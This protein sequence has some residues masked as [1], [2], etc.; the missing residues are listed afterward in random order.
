M[1]GSVTD[2][3]DIALGMNLKASGDK[4]IFLLGTLLGMT[5]IALT[6]GLG[7]NIDFSGLGDLIDLPM[8]THSTGMQVR[9]SF[10]IATVYVPDLLV[11]DEW[12]AVGDE[13]FRS[14]AEERLSALV[15][16]TKILVLASHSRSLL[17]KVCTRGI[18]MS[19][20]QIIGDG[21]IREIT[22]QYFS[23]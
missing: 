12:L 6:T 4:N 13:T 5:R 14:R 17:E 10:A 18:I 15:E 22:A 8:C 23:S 21:P 9:L 16:E 3:S 11:M 19:H 2:L 20:G 7:E 1:E